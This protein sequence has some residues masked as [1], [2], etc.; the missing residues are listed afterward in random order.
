MIIEN[1]TIQQPTPRFGGISPHPANGMQR[2]R[3]TN[4]SRR[5]DM[6]IENV[7]SQRLTPKGWHNTMQQRPWLVNGLWRLDCHV[8]SLLAMTVVV[9]GWSLSL[10]KGEKCNY[11]I[12]L[13]PC[14]SE[15]AKNLKVRLMVSER[16]FTAPACRQ[17]GSE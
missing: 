17:T 6:I 3:G 5:D 8:A 1:V 16:F 14:H 15:P 10:S 2:S 13:T 7:S 4:Q 9:A 11:T 12:S